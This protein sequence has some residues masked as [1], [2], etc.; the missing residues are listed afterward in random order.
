[1]MQNG[2][3]LTSNNYDASTINLSQS[4]AT[5]STTPGE[6]ALK[7]YLRFSNPS[8]PLY[9][10]NDQ[11]PNSVEAFKQ[12]QLIM[13]PHYASLYVYLINEMPSL[14]NSIEVTTM[15]Q[16]TSTESVAGLE[17][18]ATASK[19]ENFCVPSAKNDKDKQLASWV[20]IEHLT[21][22]SGSSPYLSAT[23][24][25]SALKEVE[26]RAKFEAF[27]EQR[28]MADTWYKG[29]KAMQVDQVFISMIDDAYTGRKSALDSLNSASTSITTVLQASN[30]KWSGQ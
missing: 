15:P 13:L 24:M 22:R 4:G 14:K 16:I 25:P 30:S 18:H 7:F 10:W 8:D 12:G 6:E 26:G 27:D 23:K 1:M 20:F 11:M 21:S 28:E 9:T 29:H 19:S 17:N 3:E 2:T 5:T